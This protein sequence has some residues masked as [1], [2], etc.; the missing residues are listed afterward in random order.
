VRDERLADEL[1]AYHALRAQWAEDPCR[2]VVERIGVTPT[3]QQRRLLDSIAP[4]GAKVS[5]RSGH[6]T[7]KSSSLAWCIFWFLETRDYSRI[8]C[9]APT[10]AQL[11]D[12]LWAELGLW[13]RRSHEHSQRRGD[14]QRLWLGSLF[15]LIRDRLQDRSAPGEW[16]AAA[17]TSSKTSP[18]ALQGF[19]AGNIVV[20]EDGQTRQIVEGADTGRLMFVIDEASG[21]PDLVYEV[22]EGALSGHGSR[23]IMAGNPVRTSGYFFRSHNRDRHQFTTLHFRTSDSP[24]ADPDYRVRLVARWG[25]DSNIVRVRADGEFPVHGD[26]VLIS[27]EWAESAIDRDPHI[28]SCETRISVD[29]ARFGDDR[30]VIMARR[31]RN[32]LAAEITAKQDTMATCGRA[33]IMR[34]KYNAA[35]IWVGTAG[36]AGIADRLMEQGEHVVE[37]NEGAG[38]P[39]EQPWGHDDQMIPLN[40]RD[41]MWLAG[42]AWLRDEQPSFAGLDRE[43]A[44]ELAGELATPKYSFDSSGR[45]RIESKDELKKPGRLGRSPDLADALLIS[46]YPD[47]V[48]RQ[49]PAVAGKTEF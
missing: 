10:A 15:R 21:V 3:H 11:R 5:I 24:L 46:L 2:Y 23:L 41:W 34:R 7:G 49:A 31:G 16:F 38:A 6:G 35:G 9:T 43:I 19:H 30:T 33:S 12:V 29:P 28:E 45:L 39:R 26:D 17:R 40:V 47:R 20:S 27:L 22:A 14:H 42:R 32:I 8:P 13:M 1:A 48:R 37:V 44:E 25:E 18:D 36:F 4:D